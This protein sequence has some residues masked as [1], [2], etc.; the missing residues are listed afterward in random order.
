MTTSSPR[1]PTSAQAHT[2]KTVRAREVLDSRG[3]PTVEVE[4]TLSSGAFGRA[5][6][7]SGASTGAHEA[8]E[9]RDGGKRFSGKG[10]TQA[11]AN[12]TGPLAEAVRGLPAADLETV[13]RRLRETDG[14]PNLGRLGANAI[15]GVSLATAHAAAADAK[16]PL[17]RF[18]GDRLRAAGWPPEW[19]L[20]VPMMNVLNGGA[21]ADNGLDVQEVMVAPIGL[22]SFREALRAGAEVYAALKS[23]LKAK[24]AS[25]AVGDEGGFAPRLPGNEAAIE[26]VEKAIE[27]AG[28]RPGKDIALA[29]DAAATEWFGRV[30][31][32]L[33]AFEGKEVTAETLTATYEG[34]KARHPIYSV[35]DGLA[36]D[37]WEGWALLSKRLGP[38]CQLVGDDLFVTQKARLERG[39]RSGVCNAIL[40]KPNQVGTLSDTVETVRVAYAAGYGAVIS[41]RS[42]ETEDVTIADLAVALGTGQIKTGAPCRSERVAK[43][44][45]LLRIEEELGDLAVYGLRPAG[46]PA[47]GKPTR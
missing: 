41:H 14:T 26:A 17:Y 32:G 42:G 22:P 45:R 20:P 8:V 4:V 25:T 24:G 12:A 29:L 19:R 6:V 33:Y 7:P 37:D 38:S 34:W 47:A 9:L 3:N 21:H 2:V 23:I 31:E 18:L 30:K 43:Y 46:K 40:V 27:K 35:E 16:V 28:Y 39:I 13:D 5:I 44:N 36:E 10:V 1:S 11:V 15:L